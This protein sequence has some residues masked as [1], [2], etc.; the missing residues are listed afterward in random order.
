MCLEL[1]NFGNFII[2]KALTLRKANSSRADV[3][4]TLAFCPFINYIC[5]KTYRNMGVIKH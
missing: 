3:I 2:I 5:E 1:L 4:L